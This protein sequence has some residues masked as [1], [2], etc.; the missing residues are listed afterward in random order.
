MTY[1]WDAALSFCA[2]FAGG[3]VSIAAGGLVLRRSLSKMGM[4]SMMKP[5]VKR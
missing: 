2:G 4:G 3:M 1:F 5:A